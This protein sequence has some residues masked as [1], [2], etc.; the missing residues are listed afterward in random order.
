[1]RHLTQRGMTLIETM[2]TVSVMAILL[3][4]GVPALIDYLNNARVRHG[5]ETL[6]SQV[7]LAQAESLKRNATVRLDIDGKTVTLTDLTASPPARLHQHTLPNGVM[8]AGDRALTFG[9][10]GHPVPWGQEYA[11][12]IRGPGGDCS[13][14]RAC[15][16]L[17]V[18]GGGGMG[19][20]MYGR[21][22]P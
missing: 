16:V 19:L 8:L 2:I 11:V 5:G 1:M 20:C 15:S 10:Q 17:R 21:E 14:G 12:S 6:L 13:V 18:Y 3:T 9:S 22:C 7:M 4:S